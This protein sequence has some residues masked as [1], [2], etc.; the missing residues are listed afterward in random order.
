MWL[1][2]DMNK[3]M[4]SIWLILNSSP[5]SNWSLR[6]AT[7]RQ[8]KLQNLQKSSKTKISRII[9]MCGPLNQT[10]IRTSS[11]LTKNLKFTST[12]YGFWIIFIYDLNC[13]NFIHLLLID[14]SR[15]VLR[16]KF[17]VNKWFIFDIFED[18]HVRKNI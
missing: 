12:I 10:K 5:N 1:N 9:Q 13:S 4:D 6:F 7:P 8:Y 2:C 15:F 17:P 14:V 16:F 18:L 3:K 11:Y